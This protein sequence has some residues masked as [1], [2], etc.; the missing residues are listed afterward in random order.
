MSTLYTFWDTIISRKLKGYTF[1]GLMNSAT[2]VR[3]Q[4]GRE[5][6]PG[7]RVLGF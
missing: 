4:A 5:S 7:F 2:E 1:L 3:F 6:L